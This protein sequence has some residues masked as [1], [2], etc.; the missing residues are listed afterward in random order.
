[1]MLATPVFSADA[2]VIAKKTKTI[3]GEVLTFMKVLTADD[4]IQGF[5]VTRQGKKI[6]EEAL[7]KE[8]RTIV[9]PQL[10]R[11]L[12]TTSLSRKDSDRLRV[13]IALH[14]EE[15]VI[16]EQPQFGGG[17]ITQGISKEHIV[18]GRS[19]SDRE[20]EKQI[21]RQATML[22]AQ[23]EKRAEQR[24][25]QVLRWAKRFGLENRE[26]LRTALKEGRQTLTLELTK[27]EIAE[28]L[29]SNDGSIE[30][31]ELY[32]PGEDDINQAMGAT[33]ISTSA[34]PNTT[35]RGNGIGLYMTES[36][37]ANE[38]RITNYD[39]LAGSETDHSRNVGAILRT[40]SPASFLYCR[41]GA[42]LPT[43]ID[44]HGLKIFGI[45]VIPPLNPPIH[46]VTRSNST[47]DNTNYT[48]LDREWDNFSYNEN[49]AVFNSGGN[50]G[51][52]TGNVR[53][54]GKG[55]NLITVGNYNDANDSISGTSPFVDPETGNDKPEVTAPGSNIT[56][57]GFTMSGTSQATP[58]AAAFAADMMSHRTFLQYRPYLL[59]ANMLAG[60]TDP[61]AGG[62]N[63]VGLGGI[64]FASA[65]WNG[66]YWYWTG[67]ND[68]FE[69]FDSQDGNDNG[70][71]EKTF[72]I[73]NGWDHARVVISWLNRGS[74]TYT[75]RNDAHPI[76][77]DMDLRVYDPNGTYVGGSASWDNSFERVNFAPSVSGY[78]TFKIKRYANRDT[79]LNLRLG[80]QVN[81]YND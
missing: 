2:E 67:N 75:H 35:T 45:Q 28:L 65:H 50:T 29:E 53:S 63:K 27:N 73:S 31:I 30:G 72:Y 7:P 59:R 21:E 32:E 20:L 1:M 15:E 64:D 61:I 19:L 43:A 38:S 11:I 17:E 40:V 33:S 9:Q 36:G 55:L 34:L 76:G 74:Y 41:G 6:S 49:I 58:H 54:P 23:N 14:H 10:Q 79:N 24:D 5:A 70:A 22:H 66:W 62:F 56:A 68:A 18:N 8:K 39:R 51:N 3:N 48:T 4:E 42:V 26:G 46:I 13:N 37:C 71:I 47:N 69:Y 78:Y 81:L 44:L 16:P 57:G 60:A 25:A 80:L 52:G 12:E 77:M